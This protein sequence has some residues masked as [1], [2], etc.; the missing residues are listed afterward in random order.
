VLWCIL[1]QIIYNTNNIN[2]DVQIDTNVGTK[3]TPLISAC[4][5]NMTNVAL[6]LIAT[7]KSAP[8]IVSHPNGNAFTIALRN[9]MT[10]VAFALYN[11]FRYERYKR[12]HFAIIAWQI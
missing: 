1:Y 9:N 4:Q 7:G 11:Y 2:Y 6:A 12:R 3:I 10:D 8:E 5:N